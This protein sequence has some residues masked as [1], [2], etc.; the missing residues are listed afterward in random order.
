MSRTHAI[1]LKRKFV[2]NDL[3][4]V[5][6]RAMHACLPKM[7]VN[8]TDGAKLARRQ[9]FRGRLRELLAREAAGQL[10]PTEQRYPAYKVGFTGKYCAVR[11]LSSNVMLCQFPRIFAKLR[12]NQIRRNYQCKSSDC[13]WFLRLT[14]FVGGAVRPQF[15]R[16][17]AGNY[18]QQRVRPSR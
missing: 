14:E 11:R 16:L 2:A 12:C 18:T 1:E 4:L 5:E 17:R 10:M 15:R 8:D 13:V 3:D 6:S 9:G 7:F